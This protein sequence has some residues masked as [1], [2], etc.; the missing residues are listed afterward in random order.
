M[1]NELY[2]LR[3]HIEMQLMFNDRGS[4]VTVV[5]EECNGHYVDHEIEGD[6]IYS[7]PKSLL[8]KS[9]GLKL[10]SCTLEE[11]HNAV[12]DEYNSR[13]THKPDELLK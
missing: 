13:V 7:I 1:W 2:T 9:K 6:K 4:K 11:L 8:K 5:Y 3:L 10:Y 12:V